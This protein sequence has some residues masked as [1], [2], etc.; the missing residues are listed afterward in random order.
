MGN[1]K[2]KARGQVQVDGTE[3]RHHANLQQANL[4]SLYRPTTAD[5][6][7]KKK[8]TPLALN[9]AQINI[10]NSWV[11]KHIKKKECV[12]FIPQESSEGETCGCG[13]ARE[14]HYHGL[15]QPVVPPE[16][17]WEPQ[18]HVKEFPSDA[19][20][21]MTFTGTT[22]T[23]A[24]YVRA[25]CDTRP[26]VLFELMTEQW[27]LRVPS[28]LIS[29][30]GGAKNFNISPR[31]KTQFSRG[32]VKAAQSTG[33]WIITGG[34]HAGVMK[35]VGEA[36]RN[37][38]GGEADSEIVLIGIATWGIVHNRGS[39]ISEA[40]GAPALYPMD[41]GSQ[42]KLCCLDNNHTHFILVD[43]GTQ[44]RYGIEI[45]LRTRLEKFI[46]S[47]TFFISG[48]AIK[49]PIVCVVLEGG[50]GTLDTIYSSMCNNT[51]C[52]IVEGS[53]R[54]ADIIAQ[55]ANLSSS[56]ITINLIKEKLRNLFSDS[57]ESFTEAQIIMWTKKIQDIV[58]MGSL[59]TILR[60]EKVGDQGMD[61]AILQAL[62]KASHSA[63]YNGQENWDHQL[64][65]A[66][67]WN[68]P[69]IAE[70][71]IF[72][73][74]WTWKPSDLYDCLTLSFIEDKPS[75]VR[76]F[77][78]RGVSL[79]EYLT[80]E[81]LT[82][83]Y[84]NTD[85]S[86][87][88]HSKLERHATVEGSKEVVV[89]SIE[90]HH[91]SRVLQELLGDLTEPLYPEAKRKRM[92]QVNIKMNGKVGAMKK[93]KKHQQMDHPVRDLLI[94]CI[95][96]NRAELADIIWNLN[97]DNVAGAL[98]CTKI[99]KALSKEEEDSE[100]VEE[101]TALANIYEERAAG[102]FSECYRGDDK[103][104]ELLL[105]HVT[106]KWGRTTALE[107]AQESQALTF[108][109]QG[110][111]QMLLT[112]TWW[113]N[114][115]VDNGFIQILLCMLLVPLIYSGLIGYRKGF[116]NS[117]SFLDATSS[118][119]RNRSVR[120]GPEET[121][122]RDETPQDYNCI[123]TEELTDSV[124]CAHLII[125]ILTILETDPS[126]PP[127]AM[128]LTK[129]WWGN[130]SVDNGFIQIL[131]CMLL[132]PLIYSGLIGYR[133]GFTNSPSFLD[134]TSSER[135]NRSVRQGPEETSRR[136]VGLVEQG[137]S[138]PRP[139]PYTCSWK[140]KAFFTAPI[141]KFYY[142]VVSYIGF[143]WLFA[144]VLMIDFQ[145]YPSWKEYLLYVWVFSILTEELRQ[146][147][148]DPEQRGFVKKS[149]QYITEFWNQVDSM[150]LG[151]F[152]V[153]L[154]CRWV[155]TDTVYLGRVFLS[156]D[157]M[158]FCIRLM[159][160]FS[161]SKVLGPKIIIL[162]RMVKDIFF[163]LFLLAIWIVSYGV[164]KQAILITNED[165]LYWIFRNVVYEPYL[166]LFGQLPSDVDSLNF[167]PTKCSQNGTD[168]TLP[169]CVFND[170]SK[171]LFPE[172]LT[173]ILMCLYLLLANI[174][175]LNL[176]IA[177]FSYTFV[178]VESHTDQVW[179]F[180]RFGLIKEYNE[181]PAAPPPFILLAHFYDFLK[182]IVCRRPAHGHKVLRR[183]LDVEQESSLLSWE[184]YMKDN[185]Q[186]IQ[187]QRDAHSQENLVKDTANS[188]S[189]V[190]RLL[191][192]EKGS[193]GHQL[194]G[195]LSQLEEQV[196]QST[197]YLNW[198]ISAL[199]EK[200][201]SSKTRI[202]VHS[203]SQD[204]EDKAAV[205]TDGSGEK[206]CLYHVNSRILQYPNSKMTRCAVP[207]ELVPWEEKFPGYNPPL[208]NAERNDRGTY[209]PNTEMEQKSR[210]YNS[211]DGLYD[212]RSCCGTYIVQDGLP[213]NPMGRTGLRGVG[214]LRWFGPNHSLHPVL[215]RWSPSS[216]DGS[217]RKAP[218]NILEVLIVKRREN[219]LWSLPGGTL[220][221]GQQVPFKFQALLKPTYL[222]EFLALLGSGTE[223]FHGYLDDPRNTDNAWIE[224]LAI[225]VHLDTQG[226]SDKLLQNLKESDHE[227]TLRWQL[228]DHKIPMYAN[229]K[230]I[231]QRTA[232]HLQAHY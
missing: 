56:R 44:G 224:T 138:P 230:E 35:H 22:R 152:A 58:R 69:D 178:E 72:T 177:M 175:L 106:S 141:V 180:H 124:A 169:K 80:W 88:I 13:N 186:Q 171:A 189:A 132:V 95:V 121:S 134:A 16:T 204:S 220:D 207:D 67:S 86:S 225:S 161:V 76:L 111:V 46:S 91:V 79:S 96:Q 32:L 218:K 184:S 223:V 139:R 85:P 206:N 227:I 90:L 149:V 205:G 103:R 66:V 166:T 135:R 15:S 38:S 17:K 74:D 62:L 174:L 195:R 5:A 203:T 42:G 202:L 37:F 60:E 148:Y 89:S 65:L 125:I 98:A 165:R 59:L 216:A 9:G 142:N 173:I 228:L 78:E 167:D 163:F 39:L 84:N 119:R 2:S 187:Q 83:L 210:K 47:N 77:L 50:P 70:T 128:L 40:G 30:T 179:K 6:K 112:K 188:V 113:G 200:G 31:L 100:S 29:V 156:L 11:S 71:Q 131:L 199:T 110:G 41:E 208:Y 127:T 7:K 33:A 217:N 52:V 99:L 48:T 215:T 93:N 214:S 55:V 147:L 212:F 151:L 213:L 34:S 101:M 153:G 54:V 172:W 64:K 104:A 21:D 61:V 68:R 75:F 51:P 25:S 170:G 23:W 92:A 120:Q 82:N 159:H 36:I 143:L 197:R 145:T 12:A 140:L 26:R 4:R 115:S 129:T 154:I 105:I 222:S 155:R 176:L 231:L 190:L 192:I 150:A 53:G 3:L 130:L 8:T 219:E 27:E 168:P 162:R 221:P 126:Q 18:K 181:R 164:A 146:L 182:H 63:E 109:S 94:W 123:N 198:I 191:K 196:D 116:T 144:Y 57:Y 19:H 114:L 211:M 209:D 229:E 226:S 160:I 10:L 118:E 97:Q 117:P 108:M 24:K 1:T 157:F 193:E 183:E 185:Y 28:L 232:E 43:D 158:I 73:E 87:S 20:G 137:K 45:P 194:D 107:L 49:I 81:T 102:V 133:K 136:G 14:S 201:F 122:R